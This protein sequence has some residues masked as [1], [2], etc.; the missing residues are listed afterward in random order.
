MLAAE[1]LDDKTMSEAFKTASRHPVYG[2]VLFVAWGITTAH[3][4]GAIPKS[5]DPFYLFW[6]CV[7]RG[8]QH[9][10]RAELDR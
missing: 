7:K 10:S 1:L 2:P 6:E 5:R 9:G 4:F 3:L 8:R